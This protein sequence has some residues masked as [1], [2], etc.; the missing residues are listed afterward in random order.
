MSDH[1]K[2]A[3]VPIYSDST[4]AEVKFPDA[5]MTGD[6]S[7]VM[8]RI[9]DSKQMREDLRVSNEASRVR[10][11]MARLQRDRAAFEAERADA[12]DEEATRQEL[13]LDF[14]GKLDALAH[15]MDALEAAAAHDPEDDELPSPPGSLLPDEGDLEPKL[16]PAPP[17]TLHPPLAEGRTPKYWTQTLMT[18][19]PKCLAYL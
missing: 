15:R 3:I 11:D 6:M 4:G 1:A 14:I 8:A 13:M 16:P 18:L 5:I 12:A 19:M 2:F 9:K 17:P 10:K 7:A